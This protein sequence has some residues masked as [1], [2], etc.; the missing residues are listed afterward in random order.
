MYS[1]VKQK[2]YILIL[3]I[4]LLLIGYLQP[5]AVL[6]NVP[7]GLGFFFLDQLGVWHPGTTWLEN[8][9]L[10]F[11]LCFFVPPLLASVALSRA[12]V[13]VAF[14]A[15]ESNRS[16]WHAIGFMVV[17]VLLILIVRA[18]PSTL[19]ISFHGYVGSNY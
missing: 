19:L 12:T 14:K 18:N 10:L 16:G 4:L 17:V 13:Y 11:L 3:S 2:D 1:T 7:F 5:S 9:R 8:N 6:L 15:T